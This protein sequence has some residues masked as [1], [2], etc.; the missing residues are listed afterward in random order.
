MIIVFDQCVRGPARG[1]LH[2]CLPI[3][4]TLLGRFPQ[5]NNRAKGA[6]MRIPWSMTSSLCRLWSRTHVRSSTPTPTPGT[7]S[8]KTGH[9][10]VPASSLSPFLARCGNAAA[11]NPLVEH[12]DLYVNRIPS[13]RP[14]CCALASRRVFRCATWRVR[15]RQRPR[16]DQSRLQVAW[17]HEP[18]ALGP[19]EAPFIGR[20]HAFPAVF[21]CS[22]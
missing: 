14:S 6:L 5:A 17:S 2:P 18:C 11:S 10:D 7:S 16:N 19:E 15:S 12:S 4:I 13:R 9:T 1:T 3:N 20:T 21:V 8:Q 22:Q